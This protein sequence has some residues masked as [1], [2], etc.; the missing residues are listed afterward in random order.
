MNKQI[1]NLLN[2][3]TFGLMLT[4]G[5]IFAASCAKESKDDLSSPG[6]GT[7]V[8]VNVGGIDELGKIQSKS[9]NPKS[10]TRA[11][12]SGQISKT[13]L[14]EG[15][16]FDVL[17]TQPDNDEKSDL[18]IKS[19][20]SASGGGI[21]A[22]ATPMP[23]GSLYRV[24]LRKQ[25][26]TALTSSEFTAG[27]AGSISVEQGETYEWF[28]LSYNNSTAV[29]EAT[30]NI[31]E[32]ADGA[33]LL[34]AKGSFAVPTG[35]GDVVVPLNIIFK[36][37]VT[38]VNI[39]INTM[40]MFAE[41]TA[42]TVTVTGAYAAPDAI[43]VVTGELIG[44][45]SAQNI[46]FSDFV[47]VANT[48]GQRKIASAYLSGNEDEIIS[49][50]VSNLS[51]ALDN[52]T[53][54]SFGTASLTQTFAPEL[55]MEQNIVLN[56]LETPLTRSNIGWA[57][58]NLYYSAGVNPY[59][60]FHTNPRTNNP[61]S[62]F[63]FKGHL[64]RVLASANAAN[65]KDPCALVYPAGRWKTPTSAELGTLTS[66]QGLLTNVLGS[67][68]TTLG[69]AQTPGVSF[70]SG[71][72]IEMTPSYSSAPTTGQN[73]AYGDSNSAT[74]RLRFNYNGYMAE[75]DVVEE[76]VTLDLGNTY[77]SQSAFWTSQSI[78]DANIGGL[79]GG[80]IDAGAWSFIGRNATGL[81][82]TRGYAVQSAGVTNIDL[83]GTVNVLSSSMMNVRCTRN[84]SWDPSAAGYDPNP[85]L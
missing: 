44:T 64:P 15:S 4:A 12:A 80:V 50:S 11:A 26:E 68:L 36:P 52:Q 1:K 59:R 84:S 49:V 73:A 72:Y 16:A 29:P 63:S 43:D 25:G 34:Y 61:N 66:T 39:E 83:L 62:Y 60:F 71:E 77:G 53:T 46:T 85:A 9:N 42:A 24:Y 57:R 2:K 8:V 19:S 13:K 69:L 51:I 22:A 79:L 81:F 47:S 74:N 56:F 70:Q 32:V 82:G 37:R 48:A 45:S 5:V 23:S 14:I 18:R 3:L 58:S 40:G 65:Q 35:T 6:T 28:A 54:R 76:L 78:N 75:L 38:K 55:G 33:T 20:Q 27:S 41:A 10:S 30:N 17:I 7:R 21:K 67:L 31:V